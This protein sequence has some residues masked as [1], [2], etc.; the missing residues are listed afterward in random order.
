MEGY[1]EGLDIILAGAC[2]VEPIDPALEVTSK[3]L[4]EG[5]CPDGKKKGEKHRVFLGMTGDSWPAYC[6]DCCRYA[7]ESDA[8]P[9]EDD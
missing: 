7:K 8:F 3:E 2:D 9:Y 5:I 1:K 6:V 4:S